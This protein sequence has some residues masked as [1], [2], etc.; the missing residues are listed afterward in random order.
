MQRDSEAVS[1]PSQPG[2]RLV[3]GPAAQLEAALAERIRAARSAEPLA[4]VVVLIGGVLQRPYLARRL[5]DELG[6]HV[7]VLLLTPGELGVTLGEPAL[8]AQGRRPLPVLGER[9]L[10]AELA[11]RTDG[12]FAPV[13]ET[14]GFA[15]ALRR[16]FHELRREGVTP[17]AFSELLPAAAE[18]PAKAQSLAELYAAYAQQH[19]PFYDGDDCLQAADPGRLGACELF[20]YGI[21][22]LGAVTR[23]VLERVAERIP[24]TVLLP[25]LTRTADEAHGELRAWLD[26]Q[27]APVEHVTGHP[28][29]G[30]ARTP[31]GAALRRQRACRA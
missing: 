30:R 7:N 15:D 17:E 31:A 12:Y 16:L 29:D 5:A 13:A 10:V 19:A 6:G 25:S 2:L 9:V 26:E 14:P 8:V 23:G 3:L 20:V 21:W 18:S 1:S 28:A 24:V 27:A 11:R 22:Q 4:P